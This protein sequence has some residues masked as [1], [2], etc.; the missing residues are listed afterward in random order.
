VRRS[1]LRPS[2]ALVLALLG[3]APVHAAAAMLPGQEL[4]Y[5]GTLTLKQSS[6]DQPAFEISGPLKL[7]AVVTEADPARG[8]ALILLRQFAPDQKSGQPRF[9]PDSSVTTFRYNS[10]LTAASPQLTPGGMLDALTQILVPIADSRPAEGRTVN[11]QSAIR[12]PQSSWHR[13]EQLAF[14]PPQ[15]LELVY[16]VIGEGKT[17]D[18]ACQKI[19]KKLSQA[20][21]YRMEQGA[22]VLELTDY[23][24]TLCVE[25]GSGLVLSN[26]LHQS[27]RLANGERST[28]LDLT[29]Q[30]AL[31]DSRQLPAADLWAR[32]RQARVIE[33]VQQAFSSR[34]ARAGRRTAL[35]QS[36]RALAAIRHDYPD[37]PYAPTL[38][39][40]S[41]EL[42]AVRSQLER[43]VRLDALNGSPAPAF[44]LASLS[45]QKHRLAAYRG[46]IVVLSFFTSWSGLCDQQAAHLEKEFWQKYR[47]RGVV[48][49]GVDAGERGAQ[50]LKAQQFRDRHGL[51]YPIL[52]DTGNRVLQRY[53]VMAFPTSVVIDQR[54]IVRLTE[55]GFNPA[56]LTAAVVKLMRRSRG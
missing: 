21:P 46:R 28:T 56:S 20:L 36:S 55:T 38:G 39:Q 8:Y 30:A 12:N 50:A 4:I 47:R 43:E 10:D 23:G 1:C 27:L 29:A 3:S 42:D 49:I 31:Q 41:Q 16:S 44:T 9:P 35:T 54:G 7:E 26:T 5:T 6:K 24:Q 15:P 45:G 18:R 14:M 19:E 13:S 32:V 53:R 33:R 34:A 40:L 37:S 22:A 2:A 52:V 17:G 48:V 25:P 11:P 51:T